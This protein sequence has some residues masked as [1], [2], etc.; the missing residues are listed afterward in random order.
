MKTKSTTN[1]RL[2]NLVSVPPPPEVPAVALWQDAGPVTGTRP[3]S[4]RAASGARDPQG[5]ASRTEIRREEPRRAAPRA[6]ART[7][8]RGNQPRS[9]KPVK[10]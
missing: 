3:A 6:S 5:K 8:E 2:P 9:H 10:K 1:V 4:P 7:A